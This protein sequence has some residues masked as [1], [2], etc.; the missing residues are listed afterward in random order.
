MAVPKELLDIL[1]CPK[2]K[3]RLQYDEA[4]GALICEQSGLVYRVEDDIPVMLV[5]EAEPLAAWR[6]RHG[7]GSS[8]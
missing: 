5:E 8:P 7:L 4:R 3:A 2:S 1:V 6:A